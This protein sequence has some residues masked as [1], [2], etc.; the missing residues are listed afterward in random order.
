MKDYNELLYNKMKKEFDDL[1]AEIKTMPAEKIIEFSYEKVLK[2]DILSIFEYTDFSQ[3]EAKALY[4]LDNTLD[5]LYQDWMHTDLSYMDM[6]RDIVDER[7]K[8]E[9]CN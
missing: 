4:V 2:E 1:I 9:V 5:V 6:L 8:K 7:I 3:K